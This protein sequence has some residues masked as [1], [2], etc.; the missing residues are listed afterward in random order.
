MEYQQPFPLT[1][2]TI[3]ETAIGAMYKALENLSL[4]ST[5][6]I[7]SNSTGQKPL[8][9]V[10]ST[11][12]CGRNR[13]IPLPIYL[14]HNCLLSSPLADKKRMEELVLTDN[15]AH[16]RDFVIMRPLFLTNGDVRGDKR[17]RVGWEWGV[18]GV[19]GRVKE[20]RSM[21]LSLDIT[22]VARKLELGLLR[23]PFV[24]EDGRESVYI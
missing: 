22:L 8:L 6:P 14:Q 9:I 15:G 21:A 2:L 11:A 23:R 10:V 13:A 24:K 12:G 1:D 19:E 18:D 16:V 7:T 20:S 5:S 4:S 17:L 3:C